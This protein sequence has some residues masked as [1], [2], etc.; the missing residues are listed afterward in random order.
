VKAVVRDTSKTKFFAKKHLE[1]KIL[2][3]FR[4]YDFFTEVVWAF[5]GRLIVK[6]L[7]PPPPSREETYSMVAIF[8]SSELMP[9]IVLNNLLPRRFKHLRV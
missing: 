2:H 1:P 7:D 3:G 6:Q 9:V 4:P 8:N 5:G